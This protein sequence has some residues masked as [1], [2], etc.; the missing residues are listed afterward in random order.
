M[1][2]FAGKRHKWQYRNPYARTCKNCGRSENFYETG[3]DFRG[4]MIG[5]WEEVYP[6]A[7]NTKAKCFED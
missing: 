3:T 1:W 5:I 4:F 2:W 6:L 7:N